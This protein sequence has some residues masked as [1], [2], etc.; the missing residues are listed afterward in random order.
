MKLKRT[1][2]FWKNWAYGSHSLT[3]Y[4]K[5]EL[6]EIALMK[7]NRDIRDGDVEDQTEEIKDLNI[8]K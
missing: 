8:S 3:K 1:I 7:V 2:E 4:T 6:D 5:E